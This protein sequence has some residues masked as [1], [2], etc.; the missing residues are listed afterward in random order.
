[1]IPIQAQPIH[2]NVDKLVSEATEILASNFRHFKEHN[3]INL[4]APRGEEEELTFG[5]G[6]L[7]DYDR[8]RWIAEEQDFDTIIDQ[9][10]D[11]YLA[12]VIKD[13][14]IYAKEKYNLTVGRS[15]LMALRPKSCL[16]FHTDIGAT[17]RFHVPIVTNRDCMFIHNIPEPIVSKMPSVGQLYTFDSSVP[18]TAINA[19]R[20]SRIHLV[21][22]GY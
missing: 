22:V 6:S 10:K 16:T 11:T 2:F 8:K 21:I 18:H 17:M 1:M 20:E 9:F 15:R 19:S 13:V 12:S 14:G 7:Y 5:C 3:G 4:V